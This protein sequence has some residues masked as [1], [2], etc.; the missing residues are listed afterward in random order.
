MGKGCT[1]C[2]T[3]NNHY[4]HFN[5]FSKHNIHGFRNYHIP[6]HHNIESHYPYL[7]HF[8]KC[9]TT[10]HCNNLL[11]TVCNKYK[12]PLLYHPYNINHPERPQC[13]PKQYSKHH[14]HNH[15]YHNN[16]HYH[17]SCHYLH[18]HPYH[19]HSYYNYEC[20]DC[21]NCLCHDY[22]GHFMSVKKIA[23]ENNNIYLNYSIIKD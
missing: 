2:G 22:Q 10:S 17:N 6:Q 23:C 8:K 7:K 11:F 1:S 14:C 3:S 15:H 4:S 16:C 19:N 13:L 5:M 9:D 12:S 21:F 20:T 18:Y